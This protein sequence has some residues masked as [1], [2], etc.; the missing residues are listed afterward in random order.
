MW[1]VYLLKCADDTLYCGITND[2]D[3]RLSAHNKG[4]ASKYTR[5]RLPVSLIWFEPCKDKKE[6]AKKEYYIKKLTRKQK[7]MLVEMDL[8]TIYYIDN[9]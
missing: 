5:S 4:I 3:N 1:Y 7:K 8:C 9:K 6:A 2:I